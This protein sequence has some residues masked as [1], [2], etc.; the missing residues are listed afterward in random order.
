MMLFSK[1]SR[2]VLIFILSNEVRKDSLPVPYLPVLTLRNF[3]DILSCFLCGDPK[4][5][6]FSMLSWFIPALSSIITEPSF[7]IVTSEIVASSSK[8]FSINSLT[9]SFGETQVF[10]AN[11]L[12]NDGWTF[13]SVVITMIDGYYLT[14]IYYV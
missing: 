7:V 13:N 4:S 1:L 11:S 12:K 3:G 6:N 14:F 5:K 8:A 2:F 9:T 10:V